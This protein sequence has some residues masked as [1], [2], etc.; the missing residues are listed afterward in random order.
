MYN[1]V[2][3]NRGKQ[4]VFYSKLKKVKKTPQS[5]YA[6]VNA[7][8]ASHHLSKKPKK[9]VEEKNEKHNAPM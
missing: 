6:I 8:A 2:Y 9:Q 4:S 3:R 5:S 1:L 7:V